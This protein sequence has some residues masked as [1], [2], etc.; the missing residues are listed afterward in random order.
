[1]QRRFDVRGGAT[2]ALTLAVRE[3]EWSARISRELDGSAA[4]LLLSLPDGLF[5]GHDTVMHR[6]GA[7]SGPVVTSDAEYLTSLWGFTRLDQEGELTEIGD[8]PVL[9]IRT[10]ARGLSV[11][12]A[13]CP[14]LAHHGPLDIPEEWL[15]V[16]TQ[17]SCL[18]GIG[19]G[20]DLDEDDATERFLQSAV[21]G[22]AVL[23]QVSVVHTGTG[24]MATRCGKP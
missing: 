4:S 14:W 21:H 6:L 17:G 23:G 16:D 11:E 18:L 12:L 5:V 10:R 15:N 24:L 9:G 1:M 3:G 19:F 13:G 22:D 20:L 2:E 7:H 8:V